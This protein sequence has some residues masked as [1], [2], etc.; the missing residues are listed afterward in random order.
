MELKLKDTDHL[1]I[2][3]KQVVGFVC[4][5]CGHIVPRD[6]ALHTSGKSYAKCDVCEC[7]FFC[8][9]ALKVC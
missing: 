7:G 2:I 8:G 3:D 1:G 5:S 9:P 6:P 4:P